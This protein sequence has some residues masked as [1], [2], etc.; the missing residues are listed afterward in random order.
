LNDAVVIQMKIIPSLVIKAKPNNYKYNSLIPK[1]SLMV[2][3]D[4]LK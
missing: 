3:N 2:A 1:D 4:T